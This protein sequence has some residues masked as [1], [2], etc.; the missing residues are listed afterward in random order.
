MTGWYFEDFTTGQQFE[1][2]P[3]TLTHEMIRDFAELT[4]DRNPLHTDVEFMKSSQWGDIIA[5]GLLIQSLV[6]GLI[7]D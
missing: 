4:G 5:H 7:S 6:V 1:T 2:R 3:L